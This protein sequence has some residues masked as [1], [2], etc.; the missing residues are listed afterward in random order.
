MMVV[1]SS[2]VVAQ[3]EMIRFLI[4]LKE[5]PIELFDSLDV[6]GDWKLMPKHFTW[7]SG[8]VEFSLTEMEKD[9]GRNRFGEGQPEREDQ[10][11]CF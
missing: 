4:G 7:A 1:W 9:G 11:Q 10:E 6:Q 8:R 2:V 5:E 3:V